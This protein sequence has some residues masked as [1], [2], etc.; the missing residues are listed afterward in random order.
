MTKDELIAKLEKLEEE[1]KDLR[2]KVDVLERKLYWSK[3]YEHLPQPVPMPPQPE[4]KP[5]WK[6]QPIAKT[7]YYCNT[8]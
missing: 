2:A 4:Y 6:D 7:V 5:W 1:N 3:Y 8:L